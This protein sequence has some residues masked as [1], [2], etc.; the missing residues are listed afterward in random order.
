MQSNLRA[1]RLSQRLHEHPDGSRIQ[2]AGEGGD[3]L[4][5]VCPSD[6][7]VN[8]ASML[9]GMSLSHG[10]KFNDVGPPN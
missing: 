9:T 4:V 10:L 5:N 6:D 3:R 7:K 2:P 8:G 1:P